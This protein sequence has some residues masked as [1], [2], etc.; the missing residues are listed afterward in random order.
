MKN[1]LHITLI[2]FFSLTIFSCT[3]KSSDISISVISVQESSEVSSSTIK[4][5]E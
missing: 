3:K 1:I 2:L 4:E 5:I